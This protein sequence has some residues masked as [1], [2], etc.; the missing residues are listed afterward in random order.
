[1]SLQFRISCFSLKLRAKVIL[2]YFLTESFLKNVLHFIIHNGKKKKKSFFDMNASVLSQFAGVCFHFDLS[3]ALF[4]WLV[5]FIYPSSLSS[6]VLGY[7]ALV[8]YHSRM[9]TPGGALVYILVRK[10]KK[11]SPSNVSVWFT[12][13][14]TAHNLLCRVLS[15]EKSEVIEDV[16]LSGPSPPP[17]NCDCLVLVRLYFF[18]FSFI[19]SST[20]RLFEALITWCSVSKIRTR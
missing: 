17:N 16:F 4:Y 18:K 14:S 7:F 3:V 8:G 13:R 2:K 10:T 1:M 20:L 6:R 15:D 5:H 11:A 9:Y 19:Y 12:Q